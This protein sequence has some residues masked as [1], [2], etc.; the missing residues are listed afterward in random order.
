M[1]CDVAVGQHQLLAWYVDVLDKVFVDNQ[2]SAYSYEVRSRLSHLV[3][4]GCLYLAQLFHDGLRLPIALHEGRVV[5]VGTDVHDVFSRQPQQVSL[6][7]Y[8]QIFFHWGCCVCRFCLLGI[9]I[10]I[11]LLS[12]NICCRSACCKMSA[13]IRKRVGLP[14]ISTA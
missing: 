11:I 6:C 14:M 3:A 2:A 13:K 8:Y 7:G 1:L 5:A 9:T 4:Y 12:A 10:C